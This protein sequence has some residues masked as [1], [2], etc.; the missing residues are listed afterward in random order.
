M[1]QPAEHNL[2]VEQRLET[3]GRADEQ[4]DQIKEEDYDSMGDLSEDMHR[5]YECWSSDE[6]LDH[7]DELRG[8]IDPSTR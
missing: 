3:D 4:F 5:D 1:V 2:K 8:T 7:V 6:E